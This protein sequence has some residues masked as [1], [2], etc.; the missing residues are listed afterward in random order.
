MTA[1]RIGELLPQILERI[2]EAVERN[3]KKDAKG[4]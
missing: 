1:K 2:I 4:K 3:S